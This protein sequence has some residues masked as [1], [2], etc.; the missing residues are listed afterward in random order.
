MVASRQSVDELQ[1]YRDMILKTTFDSAA[2]GKDRIQKVE[3]G[4]LLRR[5]APDLSAQVLNIAFR[6][7]DQDSNG[8]ISHSEFVEWL[9]LEA[10]QQAR[11][12][13]G[14]AM[15]AV[16]RLW[17]ADGNANI[18]EEELHAVLNKSGVRLSVKD[19][20]SLFKIIDE[21][22]DGSLSYDEFSNFLFPQ[23]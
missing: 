9:E 13:V 6:D 1:R 5:G 17:D 7:A 14:V 18:S 2:K 3:F 11:G 16:F 15:T 10:C 21:N 12:R 8:Y 19:M 4:A 22:S 23:E 20:C